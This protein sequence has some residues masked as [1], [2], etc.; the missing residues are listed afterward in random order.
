VEIIRNLPEREYRARPELSQSTYKL[1]HGVTPAHALEKMRASAED[2]E[3]EKDHLINGTCLHALIWEEKTIFDVDL[4]RKTKKNPKQPENGILLSPHNAAIVHGMR[5]GLMRNPTVRALIESCYEREISLFHEGEKARLDGVCPLGVCDI[6]STRKSASR[7]VFQ[8]TI[9]EFGYHIQGS[10]YLQFAALAELP[11][12]QFFLIPVENFPPY[13]AT[14]YPLSHE[15]LDR[16]RRE[17][18]ELK[19]IY[20]ECKESGNYPG[21]ELEQAPIDLPKYYKKGNEE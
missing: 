9:A 12:E 21:Y 1:H 16:G 10:H 11:C 18:E 3:D 15:A 19:R 14:Y 20:H 13:E 6:K 2:D 7:W 5:D 17:L 8:K 4:G